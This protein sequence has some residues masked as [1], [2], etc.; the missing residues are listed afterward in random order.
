MTSINLQ[1]VRSKVSEYANNALTSSYEVVK[2]V[3]NII[4]PEYEHS[5]ILSYFFNYEPLDFIKIEEI[6]STYTSVY[7]TSGD[8]E[9][10]R[11]DIFL[12]YLKYKYIKKIILTEDGEIDTNAKDQENFSET[13]KLKI[14]TALS[15]KIKPLFD[16][17]NFEALCEYTLDDKVFVCYEFIFYLALI[18]NYFENFYNIAFEEHV[19]GN[20]KLDFYIKKIIYKY[21]I[22]NSFY[23]NESIVAFIVEINKE[24]D[25]L[26][27][28][29]EEDLKKRFPILNE[30]IDFH[31][32]YLEYKKI[33]INVHKIL[34]RN[35][36]LEN[37]YKYLDLYKIGKKNKYFLKEESNFKF[38]D[39][40]E[41]KFSDYEG[42]ILVKPGFPY[43]INKYISNGYFFKKYNGTAIDKF[44]ILDKNEREDL[45]GMISYYKTLLNQMRPDKKKRIKIKINLKS[46]K[47]NVKLYIHNM[48]F[49]NILYE[50]KKR[51]IERFFGIEEKTMIVEEKTFDLEEDYNLELETDTKLKKYLESNLD[52]DYEF[53]SESDSESDSD[54]KKIDAPPDPKKNTITIYI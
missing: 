29:T 50:P 51:H 24:L 33:N 45:K 15:L 31:T 43:K 38:T 47:K 1:S 26:N 7:S 5:E 48:K 42:Y 34:L 18:S 28:Y 13:E 41:Y 9:V 12:D 52:S 49:F 44:K 22:N 23:K 3:K 4:N 25:N 8:D 19:K 39:N 37:Y 21:L 35:T 30:F 14:K 40:E 16:W 36:T 53:D 6:P 20:I 54:T 32:T 46:L 17:F 2:R 27:E 11:L 10:K